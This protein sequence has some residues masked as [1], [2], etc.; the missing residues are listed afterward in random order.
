MK[1]KYINYYS[2]YPVSSG[3]WY[4][5]F[6]FYK[7]VKEIDIKS[8]NVVWLSQYSEYKSLANELSTLNKHDRVVLFGKFIK[9]FPENIRKEIY[10]DMIGFRNFIFNKLLSLSTIQIYRIN[11]DDV[12]FIDSFIQ[13]DLSIYIEKEFIAN[14]KIKTFD[15]VLSLEKSKGLYLITKEEIYEKYSNFFR[16]KVMKELI[17]TLLTSLIKKESYKVIQEK[18]LYVISIYNDIN[19]YK[20]EDG[21]FLEDSIKNATLLEEIKHFYYTKTFQYFY[22]VLRNYNF[23]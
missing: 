16:F 19:D 10:K 11:Y 8:F 12:S 2:L 15:Y 9:S 23:Q 22:P 13:E 14:A 3:Y 4:K 17:K 7:N 18:M 5:P 21:N 1:F 20:D 6:L